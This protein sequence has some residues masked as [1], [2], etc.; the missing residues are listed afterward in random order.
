[1]G[2][3]M[4]T[5]NREQLKALFDVAVGSL[6]FGSGF[7]DIDATEAA[8]GIAEALGID[9]ME[10][11]PSEFNKRYPHAFVQHHPGVLG[12]NRCGNRAGEAPHQEYAEETP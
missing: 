2:D 1:V 5:V 6:D 3:D 7:W 9:P 8:R 4:V 10:A 12:C 11:T